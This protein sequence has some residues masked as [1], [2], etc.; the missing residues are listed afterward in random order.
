MNFSDREL[1]DISNEETQERIS[2]IT[3][4]CYD[5]SIFHKNDCILAVYLF[6]LNCAHG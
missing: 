3:K 2:S 6:N 4:N 1:T 5:L